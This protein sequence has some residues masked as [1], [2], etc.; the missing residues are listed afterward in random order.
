MALVAVDWEEVEV[1]PLRSASSSR[2]LGREAEVRTL[3]YWS[4]VIGW[5]RPTHIGLGTCVNGGGRPRA[6]AS[7]LRPRLTA[8]DNLTHIEQ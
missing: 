1:G 4:F 3:R 5:G 6:I 2:L 7:R 8:L